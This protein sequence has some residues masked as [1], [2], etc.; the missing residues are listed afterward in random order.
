[1]NLKLDW[2]LVRKVMAMGKTGLTL[3]RRFGKKCNEISDY[4]FREL[5]A[6]CLDKKW[7]RRSFPSVFLN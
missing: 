6:F 4:T 3:K 2:V 7:T 1:M 5:G